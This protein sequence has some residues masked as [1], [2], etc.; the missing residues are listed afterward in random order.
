MEYDA[1]RRLFVEAMQ[2]MPAIE[3][4]EIQYG[5]GREEEPMTYCCPD[6]GTR[7][8]RPIETIDGGDEWKRVFTC[9]HCQLVVNTFER[10]VI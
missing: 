1:K 9:D 10:K 8:L 5:A 3:L 7:T 4:V 2:I 6:C